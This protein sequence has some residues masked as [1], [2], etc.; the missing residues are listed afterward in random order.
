MQLLDLTCR[1]A[2]ENLA[3][4]EA[5]LDEA[6]ASPTPREV[7][8]LWEAPAPVV[9]L[10]R[11]SRY[12]GEA[13][14]DV[15]RAQGVPILR[16]V[17]GGAAIVAGPGCLM[18]GVVLSLELRPALRDLSAAHR[19]ILGRIAA[20]LGTLCP[21]VVRE[22]TSDLAVAGRKFSGNS[23]RLRRRHLLY[24]G[25][26]LHDFPLALLGALLATPPRQ[27]EYRSG[28]SHSEFVCNLQ[29]ATS[30]MRGALCAAWEV[31]STALPPWGRVEQL[32]RE[33]YS[34]ARWNE[35]P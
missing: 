17:S 19:D 25:T 32:V 2:E 1:A 6:E 18:Y 29:V 7:L 14:V 4:D 10:G 33:K 12:A 35:A 26:L 23:V 27:P 34:Q 16:R 11:S 30:A 9:V 15:C 3:L 22:G 5:L 13:R 8:R 20:A 28:R 31:E 24:H 21:G